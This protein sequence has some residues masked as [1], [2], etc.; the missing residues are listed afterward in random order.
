MLESASGIV[1][2]AMRD[3]R[4]QSPENTPAPGSDLA[5][6]IR[7]R[8]ALALGGYRALDTYTFER[9]AESPDNAAALKSAREFSPRNNL[10]LIGQVGTGKTHLAVAAARQFQPKPGVGF[11]RQQ[12]LS[13]EVR[14]ADNAA[15][16]GE[17]IRRWAKTPVL[18]LDDLGAA[19]DTEFMVGL[20]YEIVDWRYMNKPGGLIVTTNRTLDQLADKLGDDRVPSR[21]SQMCIICN[22]SGEQDHRLSKNGRQDATQ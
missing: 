21:L 3:L 19:K 7:E 6:Q 13:R 9:F 22:I 1:T 8:D 4:L 12:W 18:I 11:L 14:A 16:E 5:K 2:A 20:L 15:E 10:L 17:I